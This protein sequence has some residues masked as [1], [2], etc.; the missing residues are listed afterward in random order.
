[1]FFYA[2]EFTQGIQSSG[3]DTTSNG[4]G[5]HQLVGFWGELTNAH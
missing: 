1:M 2:P 5:V 4:P 3:T